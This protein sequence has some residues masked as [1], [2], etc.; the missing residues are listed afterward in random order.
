MKKILGIVGARLNSSRLPRK[1]LLDLAGKPLIE[2]LFER[3][4]QV[5]ELSRIVLATTADDYNRP[6]VDWARSAGREVFAYEGDVNDLTAR[7]D[8]LVQREQP[9]I[10]AYFCGDSPLIDPHTVSGM[11]RLLSD[12]PQAHV[13]QLQPVDG[14]LPIHEG[15]QLYNRSIWEWIAAH[16][17]TAPDKEH[18]GSVVRNHPDL[19]RVF[20]QDEP[21]FY[22]LKQRI[23]VDTV[24]DY[25]FMREL[26]R[27]WY[28][29]NASDSL[30]SLHWV[31]QEL[32]ADAGLRAINAHVQQKGLLDRSGSFLL[33]ADAV[34][35]DGERRLVRCVAL[36]RALQDFY[37][38]GVY[39]LLR[40]TPVDLGDNALIP[41][42]WLPAG[43]DLA[44]A[45]QAEQQRQRP[46]W[47]AVDAAASAAYPSNAVQIE[48]LP[49]AASVTGG[50]AAQMDGRGA[51][52]LARELAGN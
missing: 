9:D 16:S 14:K 43:E 21:V 31:M 33:A 23:S 12:N 5:P 8:A 49:A 11:L 32:A 50:D 27:R 39:L 37:F 44:A 3:L 2:R 4:A 13:A 18:L 29:R 34:G 28:A 10:V 7:A 25:Q 52:A 40:G 46:G 22:T 41:H 6:L 42:R 24:S 19:Q 48:A 47:I 51:E 26:H 1:Q 17:T 36:A 38:A 15:I 30:V 35:A 20:Y 45:L